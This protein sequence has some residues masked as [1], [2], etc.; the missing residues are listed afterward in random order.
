MAMTPAE[1]QRAYRNRQMHMK[2]EDL[3]QVAGPADAFKAPFFQH[4]PEDYDYSSGFAD[5]FELMGIETPKFDD[6]SGPESFSL[7]AGAEDAGI[8]KE[9]P[10]SLGRAEIMVGCLISA[11]LDLSQMVNDYKRSEIK[12]R[13][14]EIEASDLSETEAKKAALKEAARLQK[15]LDQL[16]KQVRWTFPQWKTLDGGLVPD[17]SRVTGPPAIRVKPE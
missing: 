13:M 4:L 10:G 15:M 5:A 7:D 1:K 14:A 6:D 12:A 11:A 9:T 17:R 2:K 16:D 8:F 3:K